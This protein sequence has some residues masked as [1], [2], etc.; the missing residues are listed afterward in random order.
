M[1]VTRLSYTLGWKNFY[2]SYKI[3]FLKKFGDKKI[4]LSFLSSRAHA[5]NQRKTA[6]E[7][8]IQK[9]FFSF[10]QSIRFYV[11]IRRGQMN[12]PVF[13]GLVHHAGVSLRKK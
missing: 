6:A 4:V 8:K 1:E 13:H 7:K 12:R 3:L 2:E 9:A 11:F 5:R 10:F